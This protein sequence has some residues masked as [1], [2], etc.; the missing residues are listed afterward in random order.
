MTPTP[1]EIADADRRF[2]D[3]MRSNLQ[4]AA[5]EF[6][7]TL[8][9]QPVFGWRLRSIG[10]PARGREGASRW[11]RVVSEFPDWAYG[12]F[13]TG[14]AD[15][16]ALPE[17]IPCPRVLD[18]AEWVEGRRQRAELAT[19]LPGRPCST[20][21]APTAASTIGLPAAPAAIASAVAVRRACEAPATA[22]TV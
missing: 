19:R 2:A 10:A 18:T 5:V 22:T 14:N 11:L 13:W 15:A 6:G 12:E 17:A 16:N 8:A 3:W 21:D 20:E 9:G 1:E 4:R 7:V